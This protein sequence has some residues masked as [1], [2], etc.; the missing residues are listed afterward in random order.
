MNRSRRSYKDMTKTQHLCVADKTY[1]AYFLYYADHGTMPDEKAQ[2]AIHKQLFQ[3]VHVWA[4]RTPFEEFEKICR[5]RVQGYEQRI[6]NDM[7]NG[8]TADSFK[9]K[10]KRTPEEKLAK[11][12]KKLAERQRR[13]AKKRAQAKARRAEPVIELDQDDQFFYIAGYTS[14]GFPYGVT[15]EEAEQEPW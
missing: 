15:W 2:L 10:P 6:Q 13:M 14:G 3:T 12:E 11:K 4:P 9:K 5:E 8:V 7:A 1:K